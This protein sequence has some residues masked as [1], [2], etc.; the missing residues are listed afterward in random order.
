MTMSRICKAITCGLV[1]ALLL[2]GCASFG[3]GGKVPLGSLGQR[4]ADSLVEVKPENRD[5]RICLIAAGTVEVMTDLAQRGG[6]ARL[7]LGNLMLLQ[8]AIDGARMTSTLWPETD[9]ADVVL[10]FASVLKDAGRSRLVQILS[11]GPTI[12]NFLG[13]AR[14]AVVLTVKGHAVLRDINNMLA[15][16]DDGSLDKVVAWRACE[17]R[18]AM[19]RRVLQILT[20]GTPQ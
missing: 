2:A 16:V 3:G 5:I 14:R 4:V 18:T 15:A 1:A 9:N 17:D 7:A 11:G 19:N 20:G 6:D 8:N 12:S 10:L 13:I